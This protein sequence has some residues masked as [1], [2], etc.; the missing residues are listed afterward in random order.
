LD[1]AGS[2]NR[3]TGADERDEER[4]PLRV[5]LDPAVAREGLAQHATMLSEHVRVALPEL[6]QKAR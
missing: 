3:I 1:I 2:G 4:V 5:H 6:V